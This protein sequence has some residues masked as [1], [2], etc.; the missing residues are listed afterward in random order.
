MDFSPVCVIHICVSDSLQIPPNDPLDTFGSESA[1]ASKGYV[2]KMSLSERSPIIQKLR[3][4]K[5]SILGSKW[6]ARNQ[7]NMKVGCWTY[8]SYCCHYRKTKMMWFCW[9]CGILRSG[10][11]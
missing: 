5:L 6:V 7:P 8:Q 10:K 11:L 4:A 2:L 1:F 9:I 3:V